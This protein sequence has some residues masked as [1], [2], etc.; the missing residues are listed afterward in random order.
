MKVFSLSG[1]HESNVLLL[2][3]QKKKKNYQIFTQHKM[4]LHFENVLILNF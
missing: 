4:S 1:Y 3:Q 2:Q